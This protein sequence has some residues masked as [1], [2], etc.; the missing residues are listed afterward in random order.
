MLH[1]ELSYRFSYEVCTV[2]V[3]KIKFMDL[4]YDDGKWIYNI[5]FTTEGTMIRYVMWTDCLINSKHNTENG[6]TTILFYFK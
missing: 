3:N 5:A 4:G 1:T 2:N 6:T